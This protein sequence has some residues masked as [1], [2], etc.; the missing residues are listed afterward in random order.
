MRRAVSERIRRVRFLVGHFTLSNFNMWSNLSFYI[1]YLH[2]GLWDHCS[3]SDKG[4]HRLI[5]HLSD[6]ICIM[7][8][9][10][11]LQGFLKTCAV[12]A[13]VL[14]LHCTIICIYNQIC[15][16]QSNNFIG[17]SNQIAETTKYIY[18]K[19]NPANWIYPGGLG[20]GRWMDL[21]PSIHI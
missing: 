9:E 3:N 10:V 8:Y 13:I 1:L 4:M 18:H 20:G 16:F 5:S 14:H 6:I 11:I 12:W 21:R 7:A 2:K 19:V 17:T 15:S